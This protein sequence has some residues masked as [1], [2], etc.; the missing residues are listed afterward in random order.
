MKKAD[1]KLETNIM[2]KIMKDEVKIKPK[3]YFV[4]ISALSVLSVMVLS[5]LAAYS[6]SILSLWVRIQNATGPAYGARR[7]LTALVDK[8][9]W[10]AILFS[11]ISLVIVIFVLKKFGSLYKVK[12]VYLISAVLFIA[13]VIGFALSYSQFPNIIK[14]SGNPNRGG[15]HGYQNRMK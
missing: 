2:N 10:W 9:P 3:I 4:L 8:F 15:M 1:K 5:L 13:M 11:I 14:G 6:I 12:V 7:N